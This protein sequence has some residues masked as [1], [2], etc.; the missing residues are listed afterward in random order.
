MN[1]PETGTGQLY[2]VAVILRGSR[3]RHSTSGIHLANQSELTRTYTFLPGPY[4][5]RY[6]IDPQ[7]RGH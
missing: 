6:T 3:D 5:S 7:P 1:M 2:T 4:T